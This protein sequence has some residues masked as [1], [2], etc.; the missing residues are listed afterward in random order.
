MGSV[1]SNS[2]RACALRTFSNWGRVPLAPDPDTVATG[3]I[4]RDPAF[5]E[6][7]EMGQ[8][9]WIRVIAPRHSAAFMPKASHFLNANNSLGIVL[10]RNC[11]PVF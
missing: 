1:T 11:V 10:R 2:E 8:M 3:A 9:A 6:C 4:R 5:A 7:I